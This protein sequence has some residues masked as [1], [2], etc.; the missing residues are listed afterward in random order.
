MGNVSQSKHATYLNEIIKVALFGK[1]IQSSK[2]AFTMK[3]L[4]RKIN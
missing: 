3:D 2:I 4:A 1:I